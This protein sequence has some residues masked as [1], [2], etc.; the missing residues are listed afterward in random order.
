MAGYKKFIQELAN[1]YDPDLVPSAER[2][3]ARKNGSYD[4]IFDKGVSV[5]INSVYQDA[6]NYLESLKPIAEPAKV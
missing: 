6:Y 4:F 3:D 2:M 1:K 5:G